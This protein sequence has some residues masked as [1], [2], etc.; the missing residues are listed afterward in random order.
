MSTAQAL[1]DFR[2]DAVH[3]REVGLTSRPDSEVFARAV[4]EG[5]LLITKDLDFS[6]S[7]KYGTPA[8][9]GILII[10]YPE[11]IGWNDL[12]KRM[13]RCV[14]MISAEDFAGNVVILEPG[15][16]RFWRKLS[17]MEGELE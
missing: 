14:I 2:I 16:L 6:D 5:R 3:A 9:S 10:R 4:S 8:S 1:R 13:V 12:L 7:R 15:A 17:W 11:G